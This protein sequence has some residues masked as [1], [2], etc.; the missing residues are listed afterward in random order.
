MDAW[1]RYLFE[2]SA[3]RNG[4]TVDNPVDHGW[5]LLLA[6]LPQGFDA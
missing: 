4:E 6:G 2:T 1:S 5:L 3:V